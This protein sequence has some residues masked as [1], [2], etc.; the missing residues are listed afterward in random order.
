[1]AAYARQDVPFERL[2]ESVN[3]DRSLGRHPLFQVMLTM[4][5][6]GEGNGVDRGWGADVAV[7]REPVGLSGAK[8]DLS[9]SVGQRYAG[10][11]VPAGMDVSWEYATDLF[12]PTT[13][14][15]LAQRFVSVLEQ[16]VADPSSRL[17]DW[18]L[19]DDSE[20]SWLLTHGT[21][22]PLPTEGFLPQR[23][24]AM[25][26]GTPDAV[27]V[28][29]G[30]DELTYRELDGLSNQWARVMVERGAG[31]DRLVGIAMSRSVDLVVAVLAVV[32]TG[33]G[34]L[35][36]DLDH[37]A[38]RVRFVVRDAAPEL[39]L[40]S[41]DTADRLAG[42]PD[43]PL[44]VMDQPDTAAE[45]ASRPRDEP[46]GGWSSRLVGGGVAYVVYTSGSTGRPKGV[47]VTHEALADYL[48]WTGREYGSAGGVTLVHSAFGFDLTVTGLF[49]PLVV[50]GCVVLA[51]LDDATAETR[52]VLARCP[53]SLVKGTPSQVGVLVELP[54]EFS[55][56]GE[57][58]IGGEVL[59]PLLLGR[60][61]SLNPGVDVVVVYGQTETTVNC[62][63]FRLRA[64]E[65]L[66]GSVVP[67]G[68]PQAGVRMYVLDDRLRLVGRGVVGRLFVGGVR[69][70]RGY[71][72]RS[73]LTASRF[74]ADPFGWAGSRMYDTGDLGRWRSDGVLE[75]V[76]RVDHQVKVRGYRIELGEVEA[77]LA[78]VVGVVSA[79]VVVRDDRLVGYVVPAGVDGGRVRA[80]VARVLPG[81]MVPSVVVA[82]DVWP[83]TVQGKLDRAALPV[84]DAD[85]GP[86]EQVTA[87]T[88]VEEV[89]VGVWER[90]LGV[91]PVGATDNFFDLGGHSLLAAQVVARARD[92][93]DVDLSVRELFEAPTVTGLAGVVDARLHGDAGSVVPALRRVERDPAGMPLSFAQQRL[94]FLDRLVP[95]NAFYTVPAAHRLLGDLDVAALRS[96]LTGIVTRHEVLRTVFTEA[97]GE[98]RQVIQPPAEVPL[99]IVDLSDLGTEQ[100]LAR[101]RE[102]AGQE[103]A[104]PF[105]LS[106]GPLLRAQLVRLGPGDHVFLVTMHHIVSDGWSRGVLHRELAAGYAE[107]SPAEA[108][109]VQYVDYA[110]WQRSWL[111]GDVLTEHM[112][113]WRSTLAGA[114]AVLELPASKPRPAMLSYQGGSVQVRVPSDVVTGLRAVGRARGATL[115]MTLLAAYGVVLGRYC[116]VEDLCV[117]VPTAGRSRTELESLIGFFVNTLVVRVDLTGDPSFGELVERVRD[118][119]LGAF[120]HQDVPF[121][122]LVDELAPQRDLNRNPLVQVMFQH[123]PDDG[124]AEG[125]L[126]SEALALRLPGIERGRL[127][128]DGSG[129]RVES[130]VSPTA[131]FEIGVTVAE[132]DDEL[133]ARFVYATDLFD[134]DTVRAL[135]HHFRDVLAAVAG[136]ARESVDDTAVAAGQL[137]S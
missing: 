86:E 130:R 97:G 105:D 41:L 114:P 33:A 96:A 91:S 90:V 101:A 61:R 85:S 10:R 12:D 35:P 82:L 100:A 124:G 64:G 17:S 57:L 76:G 44:V 24:A 123:I 135:A 70:G 19:V 74:V 131:R 66:S 5:D 136:S 117:G 27:A 89:L 49:T 67:F 53:V 38:E 83:L 18:Q 68:V 11:G 4:Q 118:R 36:I 28:V 42:V 94:W 39:I 73:G 65:E 47:V 121:E 104:L 55:P 15:T 50:G 106:T 56:S 116:G 113:Y 115:F 13:V 6:R 72:G 63:E 25:A 75:F 78:A 59:S 37:P 14:Q 60:W 88:P 129:G 122:R 69:L 132:R 87:R 93:F 2:V 7:A 32:K 52:A 92:A 3:P 110:A 58:V 48:T 40:T 120:V 26:A 23:F 79:V 30:T 128:A 80:E 29:C 16:A 84:P 20:R 81:H 54:G 133:I 1:V 8:F 98:P 119:V 111:S 126:R 112:D 31:P 137:T 34:Y 46:V 71:G 51:G 21:G 43:V 134:E 99:P 45:A 108:L 22:E 95:G 107:Q 77:A 125:G 62:A 109:P 127:Y 103:A 9:V 102:L